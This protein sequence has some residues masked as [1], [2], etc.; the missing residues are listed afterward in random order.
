MTV[1]VSQVA[2]SLTDL[3]R[4]EIRPVLPRAAALARPKPGPLRLRGSVEVHD[5]GTVRSPAGARR[6]TKNTG[7][8]DTVEELAIGRRVTRHDGTPTSR[9]VESNEPMGS[10]ALRHEP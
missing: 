5:P 7:G 8:A 1:S 10:R 9:I 6:P 3:L 4:P 2:A